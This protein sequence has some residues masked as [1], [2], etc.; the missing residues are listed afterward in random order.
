MEASEHSL[1]MEHTLSVR[2]AVGELAAT[3]I[4]DPCVTW[5]DERRSL[6]GGG[7]E[8]RDLF[9]VAGR[10][11]RGAGAEVTIYSITE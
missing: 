8:I 9:T 7:P 11:P 10:L 3:T 1:G 5:R 6:L 2:G 4:V